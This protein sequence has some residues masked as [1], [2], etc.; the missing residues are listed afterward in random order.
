M[1]E[2]FS[3]MSGNVNRPVMAPENL[4]LDSSRISKYFETYELIP[5]EKINLNLITKEIDLKIDFDQLSDNHT[6]LIEELSYDY[7]VCITFESLGKLENSFTQ[8]SEKGVEVNKINTWTELINSEK[9]VNL[10]NS[11]IKNSFIFKKNNIIIISETDT[12]DYEIR[13]RNN[14]NL[15]KKNENFIKN[16]F[17]LTI[18]DFI[19]HEKYGIGKYCGLKTITNSE[20]NQEFMVLEYFDSNNLLIPINNLNGIS[21]Y[22]SSDNEASEIIKTWYK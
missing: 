20:I 7:K 16:I 10:I 12:Y 21:R 3:L 17:D 5:N 1:K 8:F 9:K 13:S 6:K 14:K 22:A 15:N 2:R 19:V 4:F 18:D 11:P